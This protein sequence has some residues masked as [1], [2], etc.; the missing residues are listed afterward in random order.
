[1]RTKVPTKAKAKVKV[2]APVK[3][4]AAPKPLKKAPAAS[5]KL[6]GVVVKSLD[7]DKAEDIQSIDIC[8]KSAMADFIVVA[9]GRSNRHVAATAEHLMVELKK[10]GITCRSEGLQQGDWVLIDAMDIIIHI[11]RPEVR[12]FYSLEKMWGGRE[13]P[14]EAG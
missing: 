8:N 3:K 9:S 10:H 11:F 7:A 6:L 13:S 12:S 14:A 5:L 2:K 4:V 1:V